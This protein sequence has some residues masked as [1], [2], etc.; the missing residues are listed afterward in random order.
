MKECRT[1]GEAKPLSEFYKHNQMSDGHLNVCKACVKSRVGAHRNA[2]LEKVQ[3]HDR[4]RPNHE[5]RM[6]KNS[7]R[8][9]AKRKESNLEFIEADRE[10]IRKYRQ[11][12]PLKYKAQCAVNNALRDG[13]L[14]RP[15]NC[16]CCS[17]LCKPQGHHWSYEEENWLDVIWLCTRCHA[18]E[19]KRLREED[20]DPDN[21]N[22][23]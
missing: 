2:N 20:R 8:Y 17:K 14:L 21:S 22:L 6:F 1:C 11:R 13:K 23:S 18:D 9:K 5:E 4:N 16:S 10:R 15:I 12:N 7:E 3:E 19:H